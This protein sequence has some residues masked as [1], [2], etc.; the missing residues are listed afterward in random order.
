[1]PNEEFDQ[2]G[3]IDLLLGADLFYDMLR[4]GRRTR[5]GKYPVLQETVL[6]WTPSGRTPSTTTQHDPQHTF[7]L[8]EHNSLEHNI[9]RF[10][11]V[12]HVEQSTMTK[13]QQACEQH[14]ISH[15]TQQSDERFVV[16]LPTKMDSKQLGSSRL[17]AERRLHVSERRL[18]REPELRFNITIS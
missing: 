7:L 9:N 13:E 4:S 12:E 11:E 1:M 10:W 15:A 6:G 5:P 14:F 8:R 16:R 2:T 17:S 18:E 3:D